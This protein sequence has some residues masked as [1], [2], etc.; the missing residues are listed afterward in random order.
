MSAP[1]PPPAADAGIPVTLLTGF[2]GSGKTTVLN[3]LLRH[4]AM[5]TAAVI[6]N[7]FGAIALDH[8]LVENAR[9]DMILLKSGCLCCTVK[10]DLIDSLRRLFLQRVRGEV[11]EFDRVVIETTGLAD[12]APIIHTLMADPLVAA[13]YRLD[14]VVVTVDAVNGM[15]TLDEH[16][17]AVKQA[18]MADRLLLT[19]TDLATPGQ[20]AALAARLA[21]LNPAAPRVTVIAGAIEPA[22]VLGLGLFDP[23][24]KSADVGRWLRA[25]AYEAHDHH[26]HGHHEHHGHHHHDVNRHDDRVQ[27][28]CFTIDQP[29]EPFAFESWLNVLTSFRGPNLLRIKG[30][31]NLIGHDRPV[32]IHGVQTLFHPAVELPAW[33]DGDR[34]SRIVF[35]TR[36]LDRAVIAET[37]AAFTGTDP[38]AGGDARLAGLSSHV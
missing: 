27:A 20:Q 36:D 7:E 32:A 11:P 28:F 22:A 37:F 2:L 9:D 13:R 21:L 8:Q 19:K 16:E 35:I 26:D 25:E 4:P 15:A 24:S 18:A 6:I 3:G 33:P 10:G 23:N 31:V 38:A 12:P 14:G 17:E 30:I 1:L 29:V 34:R 5:G